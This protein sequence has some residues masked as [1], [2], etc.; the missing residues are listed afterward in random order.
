MK[1]RE[2]LFLIASLTACGGGTIPSNIPTPSPPPPPPP[3][4]A[5]NIPPITLNVG[6]SFDLTQTLPAGTPSGG[7]FSFNAPPPSC[8]S[9]TPAGILT[10]LSACVSPNLVFAY[11]TP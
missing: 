9:L 11:T 1:R 7:I 3:P 4:A 5:W 10:A 8:L 6:Q 2:A